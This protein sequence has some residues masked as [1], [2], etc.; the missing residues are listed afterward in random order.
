MIK[1]VLVDDEQKSIDTLSK[2]IQ[3]FT[4]N[5]DIVGTA[6]DLNTAYSIITEQQPKLVFLDIDMGAYSGFDLLEL[7]DEINFHVIFV[8][9]HE[10]F[11]LKAIKFSA[12]DYIVK[13]VNPTELKQA[14]SKVENFNPLQ[15]E[16]SKVKQMFTNFLTDQKEH[17]KITLPTFDG[18][19]FV[20][21]ST[22]L[23]CRAD[24]SYTH[25][26]LQNGHKLT[27]SKNL[28][29]YSEVLTDYGFYRCH[30][31]TLINLRYIKKFIKADGG[32]VIMEDDRELSVSK[33]RKGGLLELLSLGGSKRADY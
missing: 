4:D 2:L 31:A 23:Y 27:T 19:E 20:E 18:F 5:I 13:P 10:K 30:S 14:V 28:K 3:S 29:F 21:V 33:S 12:L 8:T 22:I 1:T 17:H 6:S 25:F 16:G 32:F 11:A 9:A 24:G 15:Q 26:H 7:F